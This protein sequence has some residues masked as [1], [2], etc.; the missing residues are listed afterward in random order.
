MISI[1]IS[2]AA[3]VFFVMVFSLQPAH[4]GVTEDQGS[5]AIVSSVSGDARIMH[6]TG[7]Q[8]ADHPTFRGPVVYGDHLST[9]KDATLGLLVGQQSLLTMQ[10][11]TEVRVVESAKNRQILEIAKGKVCLAVSRP[12]EAGAQPMILRTPTSTITA[13]AGTLFSVDV[14]VAPQT[15]R[16]QQGARE[17]EV[18]LV[19]MAPPIV[20]GEAASIVETYH[21]V[22][23]SIDIVSLAPGPSSMSLHSGQ[24]LRVVGGVRGRPFEAP[25][26]QCRAQDIQMVPVHTNTPGPAQRQIVEQQMA[27][28]AGE[29]VA[30]SAPIAGGAPSSGTIPSGLYLPYPGPAVVP[31]TRTTIQVIIPEG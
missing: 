14:E 22:E 26:V 1:R 3:V 7:A 24:S 27:M 17:R 13:E 8:E 12:S 10:E 28:V 23:G 20:A 29:G 31:T 5:V 21:V 15:S 30:A 2:A 9:A 19:S 16:V 11:L 4:A 25:P 6:P 18:T